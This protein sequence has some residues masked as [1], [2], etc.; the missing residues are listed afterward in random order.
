MTPVTTTPLVKRDFGAVHW[1]SAGLRRMLLAEA[2][3]SEAAVPKDRAGR[4]DRG[5][6]Q[7]MAAFTSSMTLFCTTGLHSWS[8][9][10]TG[11]M[12]PSS[13]FAA[14]WNPRVEYR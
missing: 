7:E 11:H 5:H 14:S 4:G 3:P 8:A 9:Y 13:R 1:W 12:S 10:D 6:G 2:E